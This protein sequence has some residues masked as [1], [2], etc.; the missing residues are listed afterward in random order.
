M[1]V[2]IDFLLDL[3]VKLFE[4]LKKKSSNT[5]WKN[6]VLVNSKQLKQQ[7][8]MEIIQQ[9]QELKVEIPKELKDKIEIGE[10]K[11]EQENNNPNS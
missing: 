5:Y 4:K 8:L 6:M 11:N 2:L 10:T 7:L 9:L 1:N 3:L